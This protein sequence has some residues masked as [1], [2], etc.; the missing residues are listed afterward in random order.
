MPGERVWGCAARRCIGQGGGGCGDR[1]CA[2][3]PARPVASGH[4]PRRHLPPNST[5]QQIVP[6]AAPL[7][8][9]C[10]LM[11]VA[12]PDKQVQ[13]LSRACGARCLSG[14]APL[15]SRPLAG[16]TAARL[17]IMS[18]KWCCVCMLNG[19]RAG[20]PHV[21]HRSRMRERRGGARWRQL[22]A[23]SSSP[24]PPAALPPSQPAPTLDWDRPAPW[25]TPI[26]FPL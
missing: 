18:G 14:A 10:P 9:R 11:T 1:P 4:R 7:H 8:A 6:L 13:A 3:Q 17:A 15:P 22:S 25:R 19:Q 21:R 24:P 26:S 16:R 12:C 5:R 23:F 2:K 20:D